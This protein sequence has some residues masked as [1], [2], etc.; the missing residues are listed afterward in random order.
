MYDWVPVSR[1][2]KYFSLT[3]AFPIGREVI[4]LQFG[5]KSWCGLMWLS[6][7]KVPSR[8]VDY[9]PQTATRLWM[10]GD[11]LHSLLCVF[12][13]SRLIKREVDFKFSE[14]SMCVW[15]FND[16]VICKDRMFWLWMNDKVRRNGGTI[17]IGRRAERLVSLPVCWPQMI[18]YIY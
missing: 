12:M 18:W 10:W 5:V 9:S 6:G 7:V 1:W 4:N 11:Y 15:L 3:T 17:L 13:S 14:K 2:Q 16:T 8:K